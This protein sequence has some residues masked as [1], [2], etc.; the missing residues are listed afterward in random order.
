MPTDRFDLNDIAHEPTDEQLDTLMK[1]VAAERLSKNPES[2]TK[3]RKMLFGNKGIRLNLAS[4]FD[5]FT[6]SEANRR[7]EV[8]RE[9]LMRRLRED[10]AAA[11]GHPAAA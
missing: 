8:A 6:N 9:T 7:A 1:S 11:N 5:F 4:V 10:I 3:R 2:A